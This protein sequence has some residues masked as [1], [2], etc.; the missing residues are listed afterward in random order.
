[1]CIRDSFERAWFLGTLHV[2]CGHW[3]FAAERRCSGQT[4]IQRAA[5][6]IEITAIGDIFAQ[7]LLWAH[8][9]WRAK[10]DS[11]LSEILICTVFHVQHLSDTKIQNLCVDSAAL[12]N[13]QHNIGRLE[14]PVDDTLFVR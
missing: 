3:I 9:Q 2:H 1:M 7:D 8:I 14:I 10:H 5:Q 12:V 6:R 4:G 11:R 13:D